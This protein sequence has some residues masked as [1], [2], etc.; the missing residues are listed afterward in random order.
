[1]SLEVVSPE[2]IRGIYYHIEGHFGPEI[3]SL[4]SVDTYDLVLATPDL[5]GCS[6]L[7]KN[8]L[9][10]KVV[11]MIRGT[12][13]INGTITTPDVRCK[14]TT[15]VRHAQQANAVAVIVGNNVGQHDI[16]PMYG[17]TDIDL[18]DDDTKIMIP[19]MSISHDTFRILHNFIDKGETVQVKINNNGVLDDTMMDS[20]IQFS[21]YYLFVFLLFFA[22]IKNKMK[23]FSIFLG[24]GLLRYYPH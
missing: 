7:R 18:D 1:M 20:A 5:A 21:Y 24:D 15:K 6:P 16:V 2:K 4:H 14:F 8:S 23:Y 13:L 10:G 12:S 9:N 17:D 11:L 19:S 3:N 22:I